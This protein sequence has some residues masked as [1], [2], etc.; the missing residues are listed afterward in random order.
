MRDWR[1]GERVRHPRFGEGE[2][3]GW[4]DGL[5]VVRF[6]EGERRFKPNPV[7][8]LAEYRSNRKP[9]TTKEV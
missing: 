2:V 6:P 3:A 9:S 1:T 4:R 7:A 8:D 5:L